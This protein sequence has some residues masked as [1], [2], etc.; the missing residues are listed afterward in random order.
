MKPENKAEP[1]PESVDS[2]ATKLDVATSLLAADG[3]MPTRNAIFNGDFTEGVSAWSKLG[4]GHADAE[5]TNE[6]SQYAHVLISD[7]IVT[8]P[9]MVRTFTVYSTYLLQVSPSKEY[10]MTVQ[11]QG[12]GHIAIGAFEYGEDGHHIGNNISPRHVLTDEFQTLTF[13]YKPTPNAVGI[14]P[15][16][17][18][19][20]AT[21]GSAM[22][23]HTRIRRVEMPVALDA[24]GE[25]CANWPDYAKNDRFS[26][27]EGFT[28]AERKELESLD[29]IQTVLPPYEPIRMTA[30][31]DFQL[32]TSRL[33]FGDSALPQHVAVLGQEVLADPMTL[34]VELGDGTRLDMH[35]QTPSF[36][37]T[38]LAASGQQTFATGGVE[39]TVAFKMDYDALL[40]YT[41][42]V[43]KRPERA[44]RS[45]S[46]SIPLRAD[47]GKYVRY[48]RMSIPD[49]AG[50]GDWVQGYGPIPE[51]GQTVETK[52]VVG[53]AHMGHAL[54]N[55]WK[56]P[57]PGDDG[58]IWQW[59]QGFLHTVWVGD[60]TRG[61]SFVSLSQQG[62]HTTEEVITTSLVQSDDQV[63]LT[64][65]FVTDSVSLDHDHSLQFA[66]QIMPPKPVRKQWVTSR[67]SSFFSGYSSVG[68]PC[69]DILDELLPG[70]DAGPS[71][72][73]D[74][75]VV[76]HR[77][78]PRRWTPQDHRPYRD[79]GFLWYTLWAEGS[80]G[81]LPGQPIGGCSTPLVGHPDRLKRMVDVSGQ[82]G[83]QGLPYFAGSHIAAED[84]AGF[85]YVERTD[86]WTHKPRISR[87]P[88]LR[89]TCPNSMFSNY[90]ARGIGRLIDEYDITG[91]YFDNCAPLLCANT[92]HGCGY[93]DADGELHATLPLL[94]YRKLFKLV[95]NEFVKRGRNPY[96]MTHAG[97][98]PA[99]ISFIDV[100]LQGEGTYGSDHT[101]MFS[102]GEWRATWLGPNQ[103]GVQLSY[104]PSFGYGLGPNIDHAE[105]EVIGT[106]RLMAMSLLH[107]THVWNQYADSSVVYKAW[108]V[109]D[110]LDDPNVAFI[111]YWQWA[112]VNAPLNPRQVYASAYRGNDRLILVLSNLSAEEQAV[113]IPLADIPGARHVE[114]HMHALP[115]GIEGGMLRCTIPPK[116]FR[117]LSFTSD[118]SNR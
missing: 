112:S 37:S 115:V 106:P 14:R 3:Q 83:H 91:A 22:D 13:T 72:G 51:R 56:P 43:A 84:P 53:S 57:A 15:M 17:V 82:L 33:R 114:D 116:N 89:P 109:L 68:D 74:Y 88:Y 118:G 62:Y 79:T 35:P 76:G 65:S 52:A 12:M 50:Y 7:L 6:K 23:V 48:N 73:R 71:Y 90:M 92:K 77:T 59:N 58:V 29:D 8:S 16:I 86:E 63:L 101:E 107:G 95:R 18:F 10:T 27:Y 117:L 26:A 4:P 1:R 64:Y 111:P 9:A 102:L 81:W 38:D 80:R 98:N 55:D 99:A 20:E 28:E 30:P 36:R 94:G 105:Q 75:D 108:T 42:S 39:M 54:A 25:M 110:E 103:F 45:V 32:T 49:A 44:I 24:F 46:L 67:F 40:V 85:Y 60:E 113:A 69:L 19:L 41:V 97:M 93:V 2:P 47:V 100:E 31:G 70:D 5:L 78:L 11:A 61:V 34:A 66:L 96:I 21:D 104:L 87:P